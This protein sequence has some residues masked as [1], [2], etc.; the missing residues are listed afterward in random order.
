M[1]NQPYVSEDGVCGSTAWSGKNE[2]CGHQSHAGSCRSFPCSSVLASK[3]FISFCFSASSHVGFVEWELLRLWFRS[4][5]ANRGGACQW[6]RTQFLPERTHRPMLLAEATRSMENRRHDWHTTLWKITCNSARR[7]IWSYQAFPAYPILGPSLLSPRS[8][9]S[10]CKKRNKQVQEFLGWHLWDEPR[11]H[12][13]AT[14]GAFTWPLS[15]R[16]VLQTSCKFASK[17]ADLILAC[18]VGGHLT[19]TLQCESASNTWDATV[20]VHQ[21][22][23]YRIMKTIV[24]SQAKDCWHVL[25]RPVSWRASES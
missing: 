9:W 18:Y 5:R 21:V 24:T 6:F 1:K 22:L 14:A 23:A 7:H 11:S 16:R 25:V 2:T 10:G 19:M 12:S 20:D 13:W 3:L 4:L 17:Q 15:L 8:P